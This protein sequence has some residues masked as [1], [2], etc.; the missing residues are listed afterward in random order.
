MDCETRDIEK[1][2]WRPLSMPVGSRTPI[3]GT[4]NS[5]LIRANSLQD[6]MFMFSIF[7]LCGTFEP[8]LQKVCK[9]WFKIL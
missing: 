9:L 1:A 8:Q 2:A 3:D 6:S 5:G 4:G 7:A